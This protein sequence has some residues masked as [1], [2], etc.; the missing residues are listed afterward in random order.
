[1]KPTTGRVFRFG[2]NVTTD[3]ILPGR[4]LDR[5]A[6]EV[7][8]FAMAGVDATFASRVRPG[9]VVVAGENFGVGSGRESAPMALKRAGIAAVI[10]PSFA[11]LFYRNAINLGLPALLVST[12]VIAEGDVLEIDV[13]R[14]LVARPADGCAWRVEN[15][16]GT[17]R[18][19]LEAGGIVPFTRARMAARAAAR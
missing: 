13:D 18:A 6:D 19:I 16:G 8:A 17:A 10:A 14:E 7:G 11:R 2:D 15:L 9:D 12:D 1:M 3:D 4:Y 5:A